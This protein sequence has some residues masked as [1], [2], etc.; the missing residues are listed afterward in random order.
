MV[1]FMCYMVSTPCVLY[2]IST[3]P[4]DH[5]STLLEDIQVSS[6]EVFKELSLLNVSKACGPDLICPCLLREAAPVISHSLSKLFNESLKSG[7][8][9]LDWVSA[10]VTLV[11]EKGEKHIISNYQPKTCIICKVLEK[12]MHHG[13]CPLLKQHNK[14]FSVKLNL[15]LDVN[16]LH[17]TFFFQLLITGLTPCRTNKVPTVCS[18]RPLTQCLIKEVVIE[19]ELLWYTWAFTGLV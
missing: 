13:L 12:L 17:L 15:A 9:P 6:D 10:H 5:Y 1:S 14:L 16:V 18:P 3:L 19:V 7:V 2:L 11:F 4:P 8:L